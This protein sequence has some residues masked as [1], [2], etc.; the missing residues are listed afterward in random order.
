MDSFQVWAVSRP[1]AVIPSINGPVDSAQGLRTSPH[2]LADA[3]VLHNG[4]GPCAG[5][6]RRIALCPQARPGRESHGL[7]YAASVAFRVGPRFWCR[8]L[9]RPPVLLRIP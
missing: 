3:V 1:A 6:P 4:E 7:R 2:K 9:A 8:R 5:K